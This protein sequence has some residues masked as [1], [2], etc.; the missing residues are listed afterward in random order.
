[1]RGP[2]LHP[3]IR[4]I[5]HDHG[6]CGHDGPRRRHTTARGTTTDVVCGRAGRWACVP[7]GIREHTI[8]REYGHTNIPTYGRMSIRTHGHVSMCAHLTSHCKPYIVGITPPILLATLH[9]CP[10]S[11]G[12]LRTR[13]RPSLRT[14]APG[15]TLLSH[16]V[17]K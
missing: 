6:H 8:I 2:R 12:T 3:Q 16:L 14:H 15:I 17:Q 9:T 13:H 5:A 7:S 11:T 1:M 4:R 10:S